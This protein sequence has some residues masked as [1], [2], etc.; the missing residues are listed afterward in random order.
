MSK[1]ERQRGREGVELYLVRHAH[2]GDPGAWQGNDDDRPLSSRGERQAAG[3]ATFLARVG[4]RPTAIL[5]SPRLRATQTAAP[6]GR[7]LHVDVHPERL[8]AAG[9]DLG[10]LERI[11]VAA[12]DPP[13]LLVVGH[14]P[15]FSEL[16]RELTGAGA[17]P[18]PKGSLARIDA[19]RPL[20]PGCGVLR[21]LVPPELLPGD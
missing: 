1:G 14:D 10:D 8:L 3:L 15:D 18:L 16:A 21:W 4:L 13:S 5:T 17:L 7:A 2:A 20:V 12:G 11:L 6:I 9:V 19:S